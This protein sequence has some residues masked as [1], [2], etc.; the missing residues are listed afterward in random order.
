M[1]VQK[2]IFLNTFTPP[3]SI[4]MRNFYLLNLFHLRVLS[5]RNFKKELNYSLNEYNNDILEPNRSCCK[6]RK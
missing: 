2:E 5:F 6:A 1:T 3:Y 4:C